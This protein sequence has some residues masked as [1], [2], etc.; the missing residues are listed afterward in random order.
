MKMWKEN[1]YGT[2]CQEKNEKDKKEFYQLFFFNHFS[3]KIQL[4]FLYPIYIRLLN[5]L[6]VYF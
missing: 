3:E 2:I 1:N 6:C 4:S 5:I